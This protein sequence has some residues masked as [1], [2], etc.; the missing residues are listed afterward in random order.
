MKA[1]A[2]GR[3]QSIFLTSLGVAWA[4]G[5]SSLAFAG[6]VALPGP[7]VSEERATLSPDRDDS[8]TPRADAR[9]GADQTPSTSD[10]SRL[11]TL[12]PSRRFATDD[13]DLDYDAPIVPGP[14]SLNDR[15]GCAPD[16]VVDARTLAAPRGF[17]VSPS[18]RPSARALR[19]ARNVRYMD[20]V[21]GRFEA[22][23]YLDEGED[24][25]SRKA[26]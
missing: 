1:R 11:R 26:K 17:E 8:R 18:P 12:E 23:E 25:R 5:V 6:I 21:H 2:G 19:A 9:E 24:A 20:A 16:P 7:D 22:I 13:L 14:S 10:D 15:E 3:I 4:L